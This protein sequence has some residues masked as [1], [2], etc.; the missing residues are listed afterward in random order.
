V[1]RNA[2]AAIQAMEPPPAIT[3]FFTAVFTTA[4]SRRSW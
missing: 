2:D 4:S 3:T 1:R